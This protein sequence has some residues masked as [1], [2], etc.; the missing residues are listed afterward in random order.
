MNNKNEYKVK[1]IKFSDGER[2]PL[3]INSTG[4]PHWSVTLFTTT[5][6]RNAS[7]APNTIA[8]VLSAIKVLLD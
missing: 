8:A 4:I 3:L 1:F 6:I 2:Y 7:K 5:Q